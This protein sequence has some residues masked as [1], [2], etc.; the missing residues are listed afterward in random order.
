MT[1][2]YLNLCVYIYLYRL[3]TSIAV[4]YVVKCS[5]TS[6]L[7]LIIMCVFIYV[8]RLD[9]GIGISDL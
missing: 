6:L 1:S 3:D 8:Y 9:R 7:L 5:T 4:S 2:M